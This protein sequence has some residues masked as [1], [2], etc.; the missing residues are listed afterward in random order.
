MLGRYKM[1]RQESFPTPR[2]KFRQEG[3]LTTPVVFCK[4]GNKAILTLHEDTYR[5][6][7]FPL[8]KA[9]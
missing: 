5:R 7:L 6:Q 4:I 2:I 1:R 3:F 9:V 8:G